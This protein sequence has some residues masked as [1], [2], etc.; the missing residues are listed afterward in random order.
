M[1]AKKKK[2]TNSQKQSR[3]VITSVWSFEAWGDAGQ[4]IKAFSCKTKSTD[5]L[6]HDM[7]MKAYN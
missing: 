7:Q 2:K 5:V 6:T 3:I 4:R 1:E